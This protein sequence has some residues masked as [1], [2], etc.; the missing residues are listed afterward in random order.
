M[1]T[2]GIEERQRLAEAVKQHQVNHT[3]VREQPE[4]KL[5]PI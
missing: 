3:A 2:V 4:G 1:L 5:T